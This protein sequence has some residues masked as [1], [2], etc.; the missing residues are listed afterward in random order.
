MQEFTAHVGGD[1]LGKIS[2]GDRSRDIGNVAHLDGQ[3]SG[4]EVHVVGQ[5]FPGSGDAFDARLS[6]QLSFGADFAG[7][8]RHFGGEGAQLIDH[9]V[10]RGFQI[11]EFALHVDGDFLGQIAV[12]DGGRHGRD[13]A[14]LAGQIRGHEIDVVGQIFP[15]SGDAFDARLAAELTVGADFAGHAGHF[16]GE[17]SELFDHGVDGSGGA[18][19]FAFERTAFDFEGHG[20]RQIAFRHGADH[21]RGFARR[22]HQIADQR[23]HG[24]DRR[25]PRPGDFADRGALRDLAFFADHAA[26]AFKL[27]GHALV[28][29]DHVVE[30]IGNFAFEAGPG[31][32]EPRRK[33]AFFQINQG[34]Q[35]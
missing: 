11:E 16:G 25:G 31:Q 8:A 14:D 12:G 10:D 33:V 4:H 18:Q 24:G 20:L 7:D 13:V 34:I 17:R 26:H 9:G 3:V 21:A 32:R 1:L 19:K 29:L 22:Q 2:V 28:E 35:K 6:A 30:R 27:G 5:I 15:G 23:V